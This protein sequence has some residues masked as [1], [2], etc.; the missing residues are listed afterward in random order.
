MSVPHPIAFSPRVDL[1]FSFRLH[2]PDPSPLLPIRESGLT[3]FPSAESSPSSQS[4]WCLPLGL[5]CVL[6]SAAPDLETGLRCSATRAERAERRVS[7]CRGEEEPRGGGEEIQKCT[8][9]QLPKMSEAEPT[10]LLPLT[11]SR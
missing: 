7:L 8:H 10:G 6:T 4:S 3:C 1:F 9:A 5:P 11:R 2:C